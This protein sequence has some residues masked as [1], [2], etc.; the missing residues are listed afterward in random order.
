GLNDSQPELGRKRT[1]RSP[2]RACQSCGR[3]VPS[4]PVVRSLRGRRK[5]RSGGTIRHRTSFHLHALGRQGWCESHG[6]CDAMAVHMGSSYWPCTGTRGSAK[7]VHVGKGASVQFT[8]ETCQTL[9]FW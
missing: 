3:S 6:S 2:S 7:N 8:Q 9:S 1:A 5:Q 4:F